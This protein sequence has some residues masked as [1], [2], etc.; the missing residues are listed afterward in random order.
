MT[1]YELKLKK[2]SRTVRCLTTQDREN[3]QRIANVWYQEADGNSYE[4]TERPK[5]IEQVHPHIEKEK[6][7]TQNR[8]HKVFRLPTS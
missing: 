7:L 4:L 8:P 2:G 6:Y 1:E 5:V 3:A